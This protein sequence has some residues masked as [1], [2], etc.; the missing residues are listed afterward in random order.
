MDPMYNVGVNAHA[1]KSLGG[2]TYKAVMNE[3]GEYV[4]QL[5]QR[6]MD[7]IFQSVGHALSDA[8]SL[9][10]I[11]VS[12]WDSFNDWW[13]KQKPQDRYNMA[14]GMVRLFVWA[15]MAALVK[16]FVD[17][18]DESK[19]GAYLSDVTIVGGMTNWAKNP[20]PM[21]AGVV[22]MMDIASGKKKLS[23]LS[24]FAGGPGNVY[25]EFLK[26]KSQDKR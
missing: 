21:A 23:N 18:K 2:S 6:D 25:N 12:E 22:S 26:D 9:K 1:H 4:S 11:P 17:K 20:I 10:N 8:W 15:G 19:F 14:N 3:N 24:N 13:V 5:E 16:G 7:G